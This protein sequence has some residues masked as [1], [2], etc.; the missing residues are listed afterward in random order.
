MLH[1][2][3]I[4]YIAV[5]VKSLLPHLQNK[6]KYF[7]SEMY[8]PFNFYQDPLSGDGLRKL[9]RNKLINEP[10]SFRILLDV[11]H[12]IHLNLQNFIRDKGLRIASAELFYY[13]PNSE[14]IIHIDGESCKYIQ[15]GDMAKLNYISGGRD[16]S[17]NWWRPLVE[18]K[19]IMAGGRYIRFEPNEVELVDSHRLSGYNVVQ[20]G[21][22]HNVSVKTDSRYC[23]SLVIFDERERFLPYQTMV[24]HFCN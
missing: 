17:V 18:H 21:I 2:L 7:M 23:V 9:N 22:A 4:C 12:D 14:S 20:T 11:A 16:S 1:V 15:P 5:V 24:N 8:T 19:K 6:D 10:N 13:F 3:I